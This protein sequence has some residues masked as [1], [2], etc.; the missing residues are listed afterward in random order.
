M[1]KLYRDLTRINGESEA[2]ANPRRCVVSVYRFD[3]IAK[4][5][6]EP[7]RNLKSRG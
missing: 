3:A 2:R 6:T 4:L 7:R 5:I 1:N